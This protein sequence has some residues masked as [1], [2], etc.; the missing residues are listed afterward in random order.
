MYIMTHTVYLNLGYQKQECSEAPK[1]RCYRVGSIST[2]LRCRGKWAEDETRQWF[3]L[4][5]PTPSKPPPPSK[6]VR[7][8][9]R[10]GRDGRDLNKPAAPSFKVTAHSWL[11]RINALSHSK[12]KRPFVQCH[13]IIMLGGGARAEIDSLPE[14]LSVWNWHGLPR[15]A[16][17]FSWGSGFLPHPKDELVTLHCPRLS[18]CV[19]EWLCDGKASCPVWVP[20]GAL[21]C[22]ESFWPPYHPELKSAVWKI[23]ISRFL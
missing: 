18:E 20:P 7:G 13:F 19:C 3:L 14:P 15:S 5:T 12:Q 21:S 22:Q 1:N 9:C 10:E 2:K 23:L 17:V 6:S 11:S 16:G 8:A 4:P